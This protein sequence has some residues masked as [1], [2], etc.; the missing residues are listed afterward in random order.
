M[1]LGWVFGHNIDHVFWEIY[2]D[3][4]LPPKSDFW[5][6]A[7]LSWRPLFLRRPFFPSSGR[8]IQLTPPTKRTSSW[9]HLVETW[10]EMKKI[11]MYFQNIWNCFIVILMYQRVQWW[12]SFYY[13]KSLEVSLHGLVQYFFWGT[14]EIHQWYWMICSDTISKSTQIPHIFLQL[15]ETYCCKSVI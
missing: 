2:R 12:F 13:R 1:L 5:A 14:K 3:D 8:K 7:S 15:T 11:K 9:S 6:A 4:S 10:H